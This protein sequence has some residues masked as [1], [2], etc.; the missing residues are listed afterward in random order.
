MS[1][2]D[3]HPH[4]PGGI[5]FGFDRADRGDQARQ[6]RHRARRTR[7]ARAPW[8]RVRRRSSAVPA[9]RA[10]AGHASVRASPSGQTAIRTSADSTGIAVSSSTA[11]LALSARTAGS[12]TQASSYCFSPAAPN[13]NATATLCCRLTLASRPSST[14]GPVGALAHQRMAAHDDPLQCAPPAGACRARKF[15]AG[16]DHREQHDAARIWLVRI[17]EH[18]PMLAQ[19]VAD[20]GQVRPSR[21]SPRRSRSGHRSPASAAVKPASAN[22]ARGEP[23]ASPHCRP[24]CSSTCCRGFRPARPIGSRHARAPKPCAARRGR[25]ICRR[26]AAAL[27]IAAS[28]GDVPAAAV[29]R[30]HHPDCR[31]GTPTSMPRISA[32][33]TSRPPATGAAPPARAPPGTTGAPGASRSQDACR[34]IRGRWRSP[35]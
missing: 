18:L 25:A 6:R 34:R 22:S 5:G 11:T 29:M 14:C 17:G 19:P 32:C 27:N 15:E 16:I 1:I 4:D 3:R 24:R 26:A 31:P 35:R 20:R 12:A 8:R 2:R 28:R 7:S 10:R 23:I 30:R 9:C 21:W 33:N 13:R